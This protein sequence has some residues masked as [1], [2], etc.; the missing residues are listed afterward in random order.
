MPKVNAIKIILIL[1]IF[2]LFL[3]V[4]KADVGIGIRW[5]I[6]ELF[7]N[8]FEEKCISYSI[9]NPFDT[10]V[11]AQVSVEGEIAALVKSIDPTQVYLPA[12]TGAPN[13]N[14]AKLAN[15]K[16]VK[17]C[18]YA[19]FFR[20]PP[21]YPKDYKGAVIASAL[22]GKI[23]TTGSAAV[24]AVQAPLTVRVGSIQMFYAFIG[25]LCFIIA[26]V[27]FSLL[28]LKKKLLKRK[29]K[30]CPNCKGEYSYSTNF[31]PICGNKL[32]EKTQ[33]SSTSNI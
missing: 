7:L 1:L 25:V 24:S 14:A 29:K 16:D 20:W 22:P 30:Y 6:E 9:Y 3:P 2:T 31:C 33:D 17:I 19:N 15:K 13:D 8:D 23:E 11:T 32:E 27:A 28:L 26:V 21:F 4:A 18:F 5:G 10:E 12:Y